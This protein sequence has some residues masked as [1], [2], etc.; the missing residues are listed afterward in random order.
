M[1]VTLNTINKQTNKQNFLSCGTNI[2]L[3]FQRLEYRHVQHTVSYVVTTRHNGWWR[4]GGVNE[5]TGEIPCHGRVGAVKHLHLGS[6]SGR[7]VMFSVLGMKYVVNVLIHSATPQG[8]APG[9]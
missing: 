5:V 3:Y 9:H 2:R 1:K 8:L 7:E 6:L 4:R